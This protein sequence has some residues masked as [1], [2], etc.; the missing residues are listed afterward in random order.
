MR[1]DIPRSRMKPQSTNSLPVNGDATIMDDTI[2]T[3]DSAS[4]LMGGQ[5][6]IEAPKQQTIVKTVPQA[7]IKI[8][9]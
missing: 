7:R 2:V 1:I 9:H 5:V 6:S 4:A 3:M 8:Q